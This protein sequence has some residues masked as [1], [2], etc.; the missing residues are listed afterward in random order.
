MSSTFSFLISVRVFSPCLTVEQKFPHVLASCLCPFVLNIVVYMFVGMTIENLF[1]IGNSANL[2]Y[3]I[4]TS[5]IVM[6]RYNT[7][8]SLYITIHMILLLILAPNSFNLASIHLNITTNLNLNIISTQTRKCS[9]PTANTDITQRFI[10]YL[11]V[12][13]SVTWL[14][15]LIDN[16]GDIHPNPRH[17]THT[18]NTPSSPA[19][20]SSSTTEST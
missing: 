1:I 7:K 3:T 20:L 10:C 2:I 14:I 13:V 17:V 9:T 12:S 8:S 4:K 16:A 6:R 19:S 15:V 11:F 5:P 18:S